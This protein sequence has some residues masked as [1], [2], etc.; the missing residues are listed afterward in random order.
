MGLPTPWFPTR[1]ARLGCSV[2][3]SGTCFRLHETAARYAPD[4]T[5]VTTTAG[6][7]ERTDWGRVRLVSQVGV[8]HVIPN[9]VTS[10]SPRFVG[11]SHHDLD[12]GEEIA[13]F[14]AELLHTGRTT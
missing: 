13:E 3:A 12:V 11:P 7:I 9:R 4:A 10:P 2:V 14:F 1:A 8:G 5:P 6:E